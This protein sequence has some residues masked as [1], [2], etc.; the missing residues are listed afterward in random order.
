MTIIM[1]VIMI[2]SWLFYILETVVMVGS[3]AALIHLL[4]RCLT[5]DSGTIS[6]NSSLTNEDTR[7]L[8]HT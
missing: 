7:T 2:S 8:T 6:H 3:S 1:I 5:L 4:C